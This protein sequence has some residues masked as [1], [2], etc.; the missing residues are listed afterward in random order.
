LTYSNEQPNHTLHKKVAQVV[1]SLESKQQDTH[2][3]IN[4]PT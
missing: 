1:F 2:N 3:L 4:P